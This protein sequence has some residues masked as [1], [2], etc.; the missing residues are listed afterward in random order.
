MYE[1]QNEKC[2]VKAMK[3]GFLSAYLRITDVLV[4]HLR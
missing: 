1:F 3:I 2:C 4:V